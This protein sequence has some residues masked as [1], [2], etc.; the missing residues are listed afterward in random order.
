[1]GFMKN[2][3]G[4]ILALIGSL[5]LVTGL[6]QEQLFGIIALCLIVIGLLIALV[7]LLPKLMK[8]MQNAILY[9]Y[10]IGS[11]LMAFIT[12]LTLLIIVYW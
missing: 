6:F 8:S 9:Q 5:I 3:G 4:T 11:L 1:M 10:H 2:L 12:C 7:S